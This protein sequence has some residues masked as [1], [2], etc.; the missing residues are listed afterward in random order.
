MLHG[1]PWTWHRSSAVRERSLSMMTISLSGAWTLLKVSRASAARRSAKNSF[2]RY[3]QMRPATRGEPFLSCS[4]SMARIFTCHRRFVVRRRWTAA[5]EGVLQFR[6]ARNGFGLF[7][8]SAHHGFHRGIRR[9]Y[10]GDAKR[11]LE[12]VLP[13]DG[14]LRKI[15]NDEENQECQWPK[16]FFGDPFFSRSNRPFHASPEE[17]QE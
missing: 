16:I 12:A 7:P 8:G 14:A 13:N 1:Y 6:A 5:I 2:L 11:P 15:V 4:C 3:L 10:G 17:N 9:Y